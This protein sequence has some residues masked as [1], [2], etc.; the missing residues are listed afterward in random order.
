MT[1]ERWR[2]LPFSEAEAG[3]QLAL[4]ESLL[5]QLTGPTLYWYRASRSA[6]ILGAAQSP[7]LLDLEACRAV[8][9]GVY[10]RTSGGATVWAGPNFLSLDVALPPASRLA[11]SDLTRAYA[12]LGQTWLDALARLG[13]AARLVEPAAARQAKAAL[14]ERPD[15]AA[16]LGLVC[17][18][19]LS[20]YEVVSDDGL[21]SKLVGLAQ[22]RRRTGSLLQC[23]VYFDWPT[24][25]F[26]R[27][28][29]LAPARQACLT[30]LL[31]RQA[32]DLTRLLGYRLT[33]PALITAFETSLS[34]NW[35]VELTDGSWTA[36]ELAQADLLQTSKY[37][38]L[39]N[40]V[41]PG[42]ID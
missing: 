12:W 29:A 34:L 32:T 21:D 27:R 15:E 40:L 39:T 36:A 9:Q 28:F 1:A 22:V 3:R 24:A 37:T 7:A 25:D 18:G 13:L 5:S 16:L 33:I 35:P 41:T 23:G 19:T 20:S 42:L 10:K 4:S 26:A 2:R 38:D 17:F 31:D 30:G 14:A 8:G 11:S 6:L